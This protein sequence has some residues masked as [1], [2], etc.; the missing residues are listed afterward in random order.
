MANFSKHAKKNC[1]S[2][3]NLVEA[4][5]QLELLNFYE[6]KVEFLPS[7]TATF[8]FFNEGSLKIM[9][10]PFY[11]MLKAL[12][13]LEIFKFLSWLF[14]HLEKW[15]VKKAEVNFK[16]HDVRGF[17][18][19][20]RLKCYEVCFYLMPKSSFYQ[21]ILELRSWP[22]AFTLYKAFPKTKRR[23]K[24]VLLPYMQGIWGKILLMLFFI[25]W[26]SFIACLSLR[27]GILSNISIAN[28][29]CPVCN[30]INFE[31]NLSFL[32]NIF[33]C[34]IKKLGQKWKN[35]KNEKSY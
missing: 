21:N 33:F 27:F 11:F 19:K 9:K 30:V 16:T 26:P 23:S 8:I 25:N 1:E 13:V 20:S 2:A 24:L 17:Y 22:I 12:Y 4:L 34:I 7:G 10:D 15:L 18:K 31:I 3:E 14:N 28:I 35:L 6:F 5:I 29:C 32:T